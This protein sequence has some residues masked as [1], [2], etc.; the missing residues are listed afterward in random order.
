M[1]KTFSLIFNLN[2]KDIACLRILEGLRNSYKFIP[3]TKIVERYHYKN[4]RELIE[5]IKKL[6][7]LKLIE[8]G[9]IGEEEGFRLRNISFTILAFWDLW[10]QGVIK[11]IVT[12]IGQGKEAKVYL[13]K[14]FQENFL[15]VKEH[16]YSG[17]AFEHFKK[18]LAYLS[19]KWR[20]NQLKILDYKID[21][22][23]A[24]AQIEAQVLNK[25]KNYNV[26]KFI[27]INR[28][29]IVEEFIEFEGKPAPLL[30]EV[31]IENPKELKEDLLDHY[32]KIY[33]KEGI[34]H[35]DLSESNIL[36]N[37]KGFYL[38]DWPQAVPKDIENGDL[39][40]KR[41]I[42]NL[43]NFFFRKYKI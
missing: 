15:I 21:V 6:N 2:K 13:A 41:D 1:I 36:I 18:S 3:L 33:E 28:H 37:E 5:I 38:I 26:P 20:I 23:R 17:K 19:I 34:I 14:D 39:L 11:E 22:P 24:K 29:I 16:L 10:K 32:N 12:I 25:L 35:G 8:Y 40:Y 9:I 7:K 31:E 27:T 43:N 30:R 4:K 42:E